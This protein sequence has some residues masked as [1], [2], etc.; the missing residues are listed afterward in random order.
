MRII[1]KICG[2]LRRTARQ[3]VPTREHVSRYHRKPMMFLVFCRNG[4]CAITLV[5]QGWATRGAVLM[6]NNNQPNQEREPRQAQPG[7]NPER[8]EG[9]DM[10][11]EGGMERDR[12]RERKDQ[13]RPQ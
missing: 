13:E 1:R 4:G 5:Q 3:H 8:R 2:T 12:Q 9:Q 7:R 6:P 10:E 11:R